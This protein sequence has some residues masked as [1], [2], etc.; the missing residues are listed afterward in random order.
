MFTTTKTEIPEVMV[1]EPQVFWDE[2]WFFMETYNQKGFEELW[3]TSRFVQDNYSKSA[4]GVF[5]G[6]HFQTENT[7]AKL[8][9]VTQWAVLDF[10][11]DIRK[12]SPTYGKWVKQELS[13]K[14]KKLFFVPKGFAHGFI[15]LQEGTEF[16]YKCDDFYNPK[17]D[18]GI[19]YNDPSLNIEREKIKQ[20]YNISDFILSD[21]DTKHPTLEAFYPNNPF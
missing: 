11:V 4:K 6:F 9:W 12:K 21:K 14:N 17:A 7:Q 1:I 19:L 8:V 20:D 5:R 13:Q 18:W 16:F 3:I 2:R 15:A 10:A